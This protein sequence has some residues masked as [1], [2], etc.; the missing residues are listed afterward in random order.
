VD[1]ERD[2]AQAL[3]SGVDTFRVFV[4]SWYAGGFQKVLFHPNKSPEV[5]RMIASIL[6]GY[7]WDKRNPYVA[8]ARRHLTTLEALC[9]A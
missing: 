6:A 2:Y 9:E 5:R 8:E 7:A 3:K 4:E 1:W